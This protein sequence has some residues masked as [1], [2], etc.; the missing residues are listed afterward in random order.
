VDF[1]LG[2]INNDGYNDLITTDLFN[3]IKIF[4]NNG[5]T[6]DTNI[7][8]SNTNF[9]WVNSIDVVDFNKDGWNDIICANDEY[10]LLFINSHGAF[11]QDVSYYLL[12]E[13]IDNGFYPLI[14]SKLEAVDLH[15]QGGISI[16]FSG[17][18]AVFNSNP[19]ERLS[20]QED[21]LRFNASTLDANP[22]P[23]YLFESY[24]HEGGSLYHPK[25]LLFN[26]GDRDFQKYR[27]YK[28]N[29]ETYYYYLFD[30][31]TSDQY[32]D[33]TEDLL[34]IT[35]EPEE[36]PPDN[37]FYYAVAVDNSYKVSLTSDTIS[38]IGY[39]CPTCFGE[40]GPDNFIISNEKNILPKEYSLGNYPNPFNPSTKIYYAIPKEGNVKITIYNSIGQKIS[41]IINEF[42][43]PGAYV[44]E[45]SGSNMS[46]GIYYY[47]LESN[48]FVLTKRMLLIK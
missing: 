33:T 41:E 37:L 29:W 38:Y 43:N 12:Y 8:Y 46:S 39:V 48:G 21:M 31:T 14:G 26:R 28:K 3:G 15:N 17:F 42:K 2:D 36:P 45:F 20:D 44:V 25:L 7:Y 22:A 35:S 4:L 34:Y 24:V 11:L 13:D 10:V 1:K 23:A 30:S 9:G 40:I 32:I 5:G 16:L 6:I 27:I 18:P 19:L 47:T